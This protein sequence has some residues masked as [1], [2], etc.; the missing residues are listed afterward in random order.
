MQL[1]VD[2]YICAVGDARAFLRDEK[3]HPRPH[4]HF[5]WSAVRAQTAPS[6]SGTAPYRTVPS[7]A[8]L[9]ERIIHSP[10][11][12]IAMKKNLSFLQNPRTAITLSPAIPIAFREGGRES[13]PGIWL[14]LHGQDHLI[15]PRD[16]VLTLSFSRDLQPQYFPALLL[17]DRE[18]ED[19]LQLVRM[20][21]DKK[22]SVI[23][24]LVRFGYGEEV[25]LVFDTV[26]YQRKVS[27]VVLGY[28]A[29]STST[30]RL[31]KTAYRG[32]PGPFSP[33]EAT[34]T[35]TLLARQEM[36]REG[37][38]HVFHRGL[39]PFRITPLQEG[40]FELQ[41]GGNAL[42]INCPDEKLGQFRCDLMRLAHFNMTSLTGGI[43][44]EREFSWG[45]HL[46]RIFPET[47]Y[48]PDGKVIWKRCFF[49]NVRETGPCHLWEC[50][51]IC[52]EKEV[53]AALQEIVG[54]INDIFT[55]LYSLSAVE[56]QFKGFLVGWDDHD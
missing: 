53:V 41:V 39:D 48:G 11:T 6:S 9:P 42:R 28:V 55:S 56:S 46:R 30:T 12:P 15:N 1:K 2:I 45:L 54:P 7:A 14:R 26:N 19:C 43:P 31:E 50:A 21:E 22:S 13:L 20:M 51:G 35:A 33:E 38:T 36:K 37:R 29:F 32:R 44:D 10:L 5:L 23:V 18:A 8:A 52:D 27:H 40:S 49:V 4:P 24:W 3:A 16:L 17:V 25:E 34:R 47:G